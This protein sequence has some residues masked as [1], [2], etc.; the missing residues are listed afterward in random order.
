MPRRS[1]DLDQWWLERRI[2][3]R[4][5]LDDHE[6]QAAY[7]VARDAPPPRHGN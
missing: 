1:V 2:L 7:R 6:A 4:K 5:L 3:V